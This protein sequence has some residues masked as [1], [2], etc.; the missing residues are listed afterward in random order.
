MDKDDSSATI[1]LGAFSHIIEITSSRLLDQS[2]IDGVDPSTKGKAP[3][4]SSS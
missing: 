1:K 4:S 2:A 3:M